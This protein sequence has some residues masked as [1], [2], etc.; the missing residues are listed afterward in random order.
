M[1]PLL[2]NKHSTLCMTLRTNVGGEHTRSSL[3]MISSDIVFS[4]LG[5]IDRLKRGTCATGFRNCSA[6]YVTDIVHKFMSD[7][8]TPCE[9]VE[10]RGA[11]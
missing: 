9:R 1:D 11:V 10:W 5:D 8:L 3:R 6:I 7:V 4:M 2:Q